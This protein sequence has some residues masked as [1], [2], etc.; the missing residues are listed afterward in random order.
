[1]PKDQSPEW[2]KVSGT[3]SWLSSECELNSSSLPA[4]RLRWSRCD[5]GYAVQ[6]AEW[7]LSSVGEEDLELTLA[8]F[9][10]GLLWREEEESE[11]NRRRLR[12]RRWRRTPLPLVLLL[13]LVTIGWTWFRVFLF[14]LLDLCRFLSH[15]L[16][17]EEEERLEEDLEVE[18]SFLSLWAS[19]KKMWP[20][21]FFIPKL[22]ICNIFIYIYS[23]N[24][25]FNTL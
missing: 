8:F 3:K 10:A 5:T 14:L 2:P 21:I 22:L 13:T 15:S 4:N 1:M 18:K 23:S 7:G 16:E 17:E 24:V 11:E 12:R 6:R 25:Y 20:F 19:L 9:L